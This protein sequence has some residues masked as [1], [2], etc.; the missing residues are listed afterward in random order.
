MEK[1]ENKETNRFAYDS[2]KGL[3]VLSEQEI[4]DSLFDNNNKSKN[5]EDVKD[6]EPTKQ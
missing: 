5:K 1:K 6:N 3:S 4:L 2:N